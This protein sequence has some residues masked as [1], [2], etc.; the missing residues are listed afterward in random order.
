[1]KTDKITAK[2]QQNKILVMCNLLIEL[3]QHVSMT[4]FSLLSQKF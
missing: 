3:V 1:M 2:T 4:F